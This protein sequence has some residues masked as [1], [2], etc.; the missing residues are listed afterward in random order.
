MLIINCKNWLCF[1]TNL[2]LNWLKQELIIFSFSN[3]NYSFFLLSVILLAEC[4]QITT[5]TMATC[6]CSKAKFKKVGPITVTSE[7]CGWYLGPKDKS[8][9]K[10]CLEHM[11][12]KCWPQDSPISYSGVDCDVHNLKCNLTNVTKTPTGLCRSV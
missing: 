11:L 5:A 12:Y 1:S 2:L 6:D 3:M 4:F 9:P 10:E 8:K 7:L